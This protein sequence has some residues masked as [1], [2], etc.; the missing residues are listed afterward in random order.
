M[1]NDEQRA[2]V[3]ST[4]SKILCL[5]GAGT[6]KTYSLVHRIKYLVDTGVSPS[7]M[8]VLTFTNAAAFEMESRY[9]SM[10]HENFK[11]I[12]LPEFRTFHA[13]CYNLLKIDE[14]VRKAIGYS[15]V[16]D[17]AD[18]NKESM[19]LNNAKVQT[20]IKL[21]VKGWNDASNLS[22]SDKHNRDILEKAFVRLLK[23][24]N[25]ITFDMLCYQICKLFTDNAECIQKYKSQYH[26]IFVDEFQDTDK[27]QYEFV[28]SF[29]GANLFI[30]GDAL[31]SL[32]GFRGADSTLIKSIASDLEWE[33]HK[34]TYNYRSTT[35]IC[36]YAN[37]YSTY[38]ESTYRVPI[39]SDK[40]GGDMQIYT[41][42]TSFE[43]AQDKFLKARLTEILSEHSSDTAILTRTNLE[44]DA[45]KSWVASQ[46]YTV[47]DTARIHYVINVIKSAFDIKY[48]N[49]WMYSQLTRDEATRYIKFKNPSDTET[50]ENCEFILSISKSK[51]IQDIYT[52]VSA[53][54]NIIATEDDTNKKY[55]DC[56]EYLKLEPNLHDDTTS[57][58]DRLLSDASQEASKSASIYVGTIHSSKGLEYDTVVLPNVDTRKFPLRSEENKNIFYV[59]LTRAKNNLYVFKEAR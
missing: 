27:R 25:L 16:P 3:E 40:S 11:L 10:L 41:Y 6:G 58:L 7:S 45:L 13:F 38:A 2:A 14:D 48:L 42:P 56:C 57:L 49:D 21:S 24:E 44:A 35:D 5:A 18:S 19:L 22:V 32:Y 36:N 28:R 31:Q 54:K 59:G 46:G 30:I 39:H 33:V 34:L 51:R 12:R 9:R 55:L 20:G 47:T 50:I 53:I 26:Y 4:H 8:L 29:E 43:P 23:K 1:L 37:E 17:I 52:D 15:G